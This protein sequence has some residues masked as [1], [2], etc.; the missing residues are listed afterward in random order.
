MAIAGGAAIFTSCTRQ[1][2]SPLHTASI[3]QNTCTGCGD[4]ADVCSENAILLDTPSRFA[5]NME[6]CTECGDCV[7]SCE[8]DAIQV[9]N[10]IYHLDSESCVGCG[11]CVDVCVDEGN[12][13]YWERTEYKVR[14]KCKTNRCDLQCMTACPEDAI[15]IVNGE[16]VIDVARCTRCG[17]CVSVCPLEAINPA[18][19]YL[20]EA[21][22]ISCGRCIGVCEFDVITKEYTGDCETGIDMEKCKACGA[23]LSVCP[24]GAIEADLHTASVIRENCT[25]CG[26]C[27]DVCPLNAIRLY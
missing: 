1:G 12:C 26:D 16:A 17:E 2:V 11:K 7:P 13:I 24:E 6:T 10:T 20:D 14:G 3:C 15:S 25:A 18:H 9:A 5:I 19:V 27:V 22:C 23:C 21:Q 4:C 8:Y